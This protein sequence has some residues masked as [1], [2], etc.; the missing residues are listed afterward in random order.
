MS[1][2]RADTGAWPWETRGVRIL[3]VLHGRLEFARAVRA[4]LEVFQPDEVVVEIPGVLERSW[5]SA[6][7][8]LPRR[9]S[10]LRIELERDTVRWMLVEPSDACVE[11]GRWARERSLALRA[12]DLLLPDYSP[13]RERLPDPA[14]LGEV[15]YAAYVRAWL[16][17][18]PEEG[19][20]DDA[21]REQS[22]AAAALDA[23]GEGR[24]VA[25]VVGLAHLS[26]VLEL[27]D[28]GASAQP[29]ARQLKPGVAVV[30]VHPESLAEV[31]SEMPFVQA[32]WERARAG[33]EP[34]C[35]YEA[36][37]R[38]GTAEGRVVRFPGGDEGRE[39]REEAGPKPEDPE[40]V[41]ELRAKEQ[42]EDPLFRPRILFRLVEQAERL[43]RQTSGSVSVA[44]T[45]STAPS[46]GPESGEKVKVTWQF[47]YSASPSRTLVLR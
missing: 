33:V 36:P 27:V 14:T 13:R 25:L 44:T 19:D 43:A 9:V 28:E 22:L 21:L 38:K 20:Q 12:G 40:L 30:P 34:V 18:A 17:H 2:I 24:R 11:A 29:L 37:G 16:D 46:V 45:P 35:A 4:H 47:D 7:D 23:S 31:G 6:L 1:A 5:F 42:G 41:D 15:G 39:A 32:A 10:A 3:P 26:R 8:Q